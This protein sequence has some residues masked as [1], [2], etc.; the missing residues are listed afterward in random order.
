MYKKIF[1]LFVALSF[2]VANADTKD[3]DLKNLQWNR[4][5]DGNFTVLSIDDKQ[6]R[7]LIKKIP[8]IL[9]SSA[10]DWSIDPKSFV[11]FSKECRIF[12]VPNKDLL[13]KLFD[14]DSSRVELRKNSNNE[15]EISVI[16][17]S[18]DSFDVDLVSPFL[19]R[20]AFFE[21]GEKNFYFPWWFIRSTELLNSSLKLKVDTLSRFLDSDK[22]ISCETIL[23]TSYQDYL[24][25]IKEDQEKFDAQSLILTLMLRKELGLIK[26]Y[27]FV[28]ADS[29]YEN[30]E[31]RLKKVYGYLD[32]GDLQNKYSMFYRDFL[33]DFTLNKVPVSYLRP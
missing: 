9:Y 3:N 16:W 6:G 17:L 27:S 33:E 4:Y 10:K 31:D 23:K 5:V 25:L 20:P 32:M 30:L 14:I 7:W 11:S 26:F 1:F 21:F 12:C 2:S 13:K 29:P 8:D 24:K 22:L 19:L 28:S 15:I 18:L